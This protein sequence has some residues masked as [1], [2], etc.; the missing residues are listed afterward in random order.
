MFRKAPPVPQSAVQVVVTDAAPCEKQL[1]LCL[2][3][4]AVSPVRATV[5]EEFRREAELPGFR[6]GKAPTDLVERTYGASIHE[7]TLHRVTKRVLEQAVKDHRLKP[8]G[9]FAL[10]EVRFSPTEGVTFQAKVEVEPS[11]PLG[12][13]TGIALTRRSVVVTPEEIQQALTQLQGSM[14]QLVPTGEGAAKER[15][16]PALDD[17]LAK[18]LGFTTLEELRQHVEAKLREQKRRAG[19]QA[20][21]AELC[22]A[23]LARHTL[24]VPATLVGHQTE[25]LARDFKARLLLSGVPESQVE[26][27][28]ATFTQ[29]LRTNAERLVKLGFILERIA[30]QESITVTQE[31]LVE[32]LWRLSE[33]WK[34]DPAEVR[35]IFDA[36]GLWPSV[37]STI[38]QEQTIALLLREAQINEDTLQ[39]TGK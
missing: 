35:K 31:L 2:P 22:E 24:S 20:L 19:E 4:E 28:L 5:L 15:Q 27:E 26:G 14:A 13:Y 37:V 29:Q 32:K 9:P 25:R 7:E 39:P 33:R 36:Q 23:L 16:I 11:F 8:V 3:P 12:S 38:R 21:E 1:R 17:E 18:D 34:K 10:S 30:E 6:K